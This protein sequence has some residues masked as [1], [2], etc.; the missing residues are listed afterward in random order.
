MFCAD[1]GAT[2][3]MDAAINSASPARA[4]GSAKYLAVLN[5]GFLFNAWSCQAFGQFTVVSAKGDIVFP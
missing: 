1:D 3:M 4:P 5:F 2:P